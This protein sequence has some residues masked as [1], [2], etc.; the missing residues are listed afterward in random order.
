MKLEPWPILK[1]R[2]VLQLKKLRLKLNVSRND[3]KWH[4]GKFDMKAVESLAERLN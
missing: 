4:N 2:D 1:Y 3:F